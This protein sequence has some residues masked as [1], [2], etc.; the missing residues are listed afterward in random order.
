LAQACST[1]SRSAASRSVE[2]VGEELV[3]VEAEAVA[4][5]EEVSLDVDGPPDEL[6]PVQAARISMAVAATAAAVRPE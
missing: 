6:P 5:D 4:D 3:M 1:A 2:L